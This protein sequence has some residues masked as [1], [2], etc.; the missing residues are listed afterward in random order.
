MSITLD[1]I[2]LPEDLWWEDETDWT[3]VAQSDTEFSVTGSLMI[4][5]GVK[6]AGRPIT[7]AGAEDA[8]IV[9]RSTIL[10]LMAKVA[11]P[12]HEMTLAIDARSFTVVFRHG[13]GNPVEAVPM[14]KKSPPADED[15]YWL[16]IRLLEV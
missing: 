9:A 1:G 14:Y 3:P 6:Q 15:Y 2:E 13:D 12:A 7:L 11:I 4:D 16:T 8:S 10:A 5:T